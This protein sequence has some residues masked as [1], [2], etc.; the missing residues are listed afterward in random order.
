MCV[1]T[2]V[3][4]P[5]ENAHPPRTHLVSRHRP[6][7]GSEG[8]RFLVSEIPLYSEKESL[9]SLPCGD[10]LSER[11]GSC[12]TCEIDSQ[13]CEIDSTILYNLFRRSCHAMKLLALSDK[14]LLVII[15][16]QT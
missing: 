10:L 12:T 6:T 1:R 16:V 9:R 11:M 3:P 4:R 14:I 7:V 8:M 13:K 5:Y 15:E 2:G